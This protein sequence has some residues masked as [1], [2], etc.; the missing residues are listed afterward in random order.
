MRT[1]AGLF[2]IFL[3]F[4]PLVAQGQSDNEPTYASDGDWSGDCTSTSDKTETCLFE[5]ARTLFGNSTKCT[6][7]R[8]AAFL[9]P[10][11]DVGRKKAPAARGQECTVQDLPDN[12]TFPTRKDRCVTGNGDPGDTVA[13]LP[14][15]VAD[16]EGEYRRTGD[17][18]FVWYECASLAWTQRSGP[19]TEVWYAPMLQCS[20]GNYG[21]AGDGDDFRLWKPPL[22]H[23]LVAGLP[24]C[25][26]TTEDDVYEVTDLATLPTQIPVGGGVE[27]A[28]YRCKPNGNW[29]LHWEKD[30]LVYDAICR[31]KW[32]RNIWN[33]S[34]DLADISACNTTRAG[35]IYQVEDAASASDCSVG[36]GTDVNT[37]RCNGATWSDAAF[38][39]AGLWIPLSVT[40]SESMPRDAEER[41]KR[42]QRDARIA[43]GEFRILEQIPGAQ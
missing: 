29:G 41:R 18:P 32:Q 13:D 25:D 19:T 9:C 36:L 42:G 7:S 5:L 1:A 38:R 40:D 22:G 26:A 16:R 10:L 30:S 14:S 8:A 31:T 39:T 11:T 15:C 3:V 28:Q 6:V 37:C 17:D 2:L 33:D 4:M 27:T 35:W 24:A 21:D 20:D 12:V 23:V 43:T 34:G